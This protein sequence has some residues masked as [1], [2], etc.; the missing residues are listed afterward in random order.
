MAISAILTWLNLANYLVFA[1]VKQSK[2]LDGLDTNTLT[3]R[4]LSLYT[5]LEGGFVTGFIHCLPD[6]WLR[7]GTIPV[8][9][10]GSMICNV[11]SNRN[12]GSRILLTLLSCI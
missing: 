10:G 2:S 3:S 6:R 9:I 5:V 7:G 1:G 12:G 8:S 4:L 11:A